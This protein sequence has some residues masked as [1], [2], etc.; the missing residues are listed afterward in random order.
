MEINLFTI[1]S[2]SVIRSVHCTSL[3]LQSLVGKQ[4]DRQ[5]SSGAQADPSTQHAQNTHVCVCVCVCGSVDTYS[6]T[7]H[8]LLAPVN[9]RACQTASVVETGDQTARMNPKTKRG[10]EESVCERERKGG[11]S[12]EESQTHIDTD[13]PATSW[14]ARM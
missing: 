12:P 7:H 14:F 10:G 9:L 1:M 4:R 8:W 2:W 6:C 11:T 5:A 13:I 3:L